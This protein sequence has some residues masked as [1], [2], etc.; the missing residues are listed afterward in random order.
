VIA[1]TV[2]IE[3]IWKTTIFLTV[4][5]AL[6]CRST[7]VADPGSIVFGGAVSVLNFHLI[8]LLVSRLMSPAAGQQLSLI[9]A[10]KFLLLLTLIA[11]ALKRLPIDL[12]SF[13]LGT[14]TIVLAIVLDAVW[15]GDRIDAADSADGAH[16]EEKPGS[17]R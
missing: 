17:S 10:L 12:A 5:L 11:V 7:N 2:K 14:G 9:V 16:G 3:R 1:R 13:L 4:V 6:L 8:R 15:L